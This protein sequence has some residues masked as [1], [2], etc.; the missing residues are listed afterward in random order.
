VVTH[1]VAWKVNAQSRKMEWIPQP[2]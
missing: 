2:L 1:A